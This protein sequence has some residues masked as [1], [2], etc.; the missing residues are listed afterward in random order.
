MKVKS[1]GKG[2]ATKLLGK[3][4]RILGGI[5]TEGTMDAAE[6]FPFMTILLGMVEMIL[7]RVVTVET[8]VVMVVIVAVTEEPM[9]ASDG[10]GITGRFELSG[11]AEMLVSSSSLS[12]SERSKPE[13][14][15]TKFLPVEG[16]EISAGVL[17]Q[18]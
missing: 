11:L 5:G 10:D 18:A 12:I 14:D 1:P 17:E 4:G 16:G 3:V 8:T 15:A 9:E 2:G 6:T 13:M 7:G